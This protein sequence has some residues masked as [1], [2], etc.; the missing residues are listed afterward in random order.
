MARIGRVI[1]WFVGVKEGSFIVARFGSERGED[2][3]L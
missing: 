1:I 3:R 2:Y